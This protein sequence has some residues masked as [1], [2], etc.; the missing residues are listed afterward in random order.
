MSAKDL[1]ERRVYYHIYNCG[2]EKRIIFNDAQDYETFEGFLKD[3]LT[4]PAD[5]ESTKKV[6]TVHGR[7]FKGTP[8]QPKNY[9]GKIE[10][11]AYGLMPNHFHLLIHQKIHGSLEGFIRSLCTRYSMYFNKK[12]HRTGSLFEGPYKSVQIKDT[13]KFSP[14]ISFIHHGPN[15]YSSYPEYSGKRKTSWVNTK[16]IPFRETH[17]QNQTGNGLLDGIT[18]ENDTQYLERRSLTGNVEITEKTGSRIPEISVIFVIFLLL[19]GLGL[20]NINISMAPSVLSESVQPTN[21]PE[22]KTMMIVKITEGASNVSIRQGPAAD[23]EKI[24]EANDGDSFEFVSVNSGWYEVKL[25]DIDSTGFIS[26]KYT[27][28]EETNN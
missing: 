25:T 6:F 10:L 14:L 28:L 13:S 27:Y 5:P 15:D 16:S 22:P 18:F 21:S 11:I 26:S 23:S 9:F 3:Y 19:V 1:S 4:P 2:V 20:R 12:H 24:G 8:H 17:E 7:S